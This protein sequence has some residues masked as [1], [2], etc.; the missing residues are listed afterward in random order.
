MAW[1]HSYRQRALLTCFAAGRSKGDR[2]VLTAEINLAY[3]ASFTVEDDLVRGC[4]FWKS[5]HLSWRAGDFLTALHEFDLG[6]GSI[7]IVLHDI[8]AGRQVGAIDA[9]IV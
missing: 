4:L 2:G 9:G 6:V 8:I 3:A 1:D 7:D 5:L